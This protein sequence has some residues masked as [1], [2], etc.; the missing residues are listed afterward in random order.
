M[1]QLK[2]TVDVS[3]YLLTMP[4][5]LSNGT[6]FDTLKSALS[7]GVSLLQWREKEGNTGELYRQAMAVQQLAL[8]YQI[9]FIIN[10]RVDVALALDADGVHVGQDDLPAN[11]ARKL[12]G[13]NKILGVSAGNLEEALQAEKDGADYIGVGAVFPTG[14]KKDA[15]PISLEA[16]KEIC[17][18]VTI[19]VVAIGGITIDKVPL[20]RGN[21]AKGV[22]VIS[23]V[24]N[25]ENPAEAVRNIK[26][27]MCG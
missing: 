16:F 3:V 27:A 5:A 7:G 14:S 11:E 4:R 9:P 13:P 24:W 8:D 21:G 19:P 17:E 1:N 25:A 10:D 18:H 20:L 12:I 15:M 6:Y 2:K 23:S 22:A 26:N